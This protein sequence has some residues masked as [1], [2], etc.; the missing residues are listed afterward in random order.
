[1]ENETKKQTFDELSLSLP[2]PGARTIRRPMIIAAVVFILVLL[3]LSIWL[4]ETTNNM[5]P[6]EEVFMLGREPAIVPSLMPK[7]D[8]RLLTQEP[9]PPP[10]P[11]VIV[12]KE[13]EPPPSPIP[14]YALPPEA[15]D[16]MIEE[17]RR[18]RLLARE[19]ARSSEPFFFNRAKTS[20]DVPSASGVGHSGRRISAGTRIAAVLKTEISSGTRALVRAEVSQPVFGAYLPDEPLLPPGAELR[21]RF[22]GRSTTS[23]KRIDV[24]WESLRLPV[25]QSIPIRGARTIDFQGKR[26]LEAKTEHH[27][28]EQLAANAVSGAL[29]GITRPSGSST[30]IAQNA[31]LGSAAGVGQRAVAPYRNIRPSLTVP[32]RT[33]FYVVLS[34]DV[35]VP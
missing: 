30:S 12:V 32:S 27:F 2:R 7:E 20:A 33:P 22:D 16:P 15:V 24:I 34:N 26:G 6:G 14:V 29:A 1:M 11:Q 35:F 8:Y 10:S 4:Q 19:E 9:P 25:G 17:L 21:G 13:P 18:Q 3:A 5:A 28:A 23:N 31:L